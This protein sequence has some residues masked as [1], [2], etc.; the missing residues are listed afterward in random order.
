MEFVSDLRDAHKDDSPISNERVFA[1]Y[2]FRIETALIEGENVIADAT[3]VTGRARQNLVDIAQR[4]SAQVRYVVFSNISES[5]RRNKSRAKDQIV[6]DEAMSRMIQNFG[7]S[8]VDLGNQDAPV[9][10]MAS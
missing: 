1:I 6:P 9:A 3:N 10:Y 2:H 4:N 8:V 7:Q 5:I